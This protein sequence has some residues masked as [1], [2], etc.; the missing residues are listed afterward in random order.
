MNQIEDILSKLTLEQKADLCSGLN[1]WNTYP[2]AELGIPEI[3]MTD[4]PHGLR[5]HY[6]EDTAMLETSLPAT[7]FPPAATAACSWD[8]DLLYRIGSALGSEARSQGVSLSLIH[9]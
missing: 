3:L 1:A 8:K 2:I 4:G 7:C 6:D 5:K 9:I